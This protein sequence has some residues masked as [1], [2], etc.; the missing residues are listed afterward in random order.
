[1]ASC[2]GKGICC[3]DMLANWISLCIALCVTL[4]TRPCIIGTTLSIV[5]LHLTVHHVNS[6]H[7]NTFCSELHSSSLMGVIEFSSYN[8]LFAR[9]C[10]DHNQLKVDIGCTVTNGYAPVLA[11]FK[12]PETNLFGHSDGLGRDFSE[13]TL[14]EGSYHGQGNPRQGTEFYQAVDVCRVGRSIAEGEDSSLFLTSSTTGSVWSHSMFSLIPSWVKRTLFKRETLTNAPQHH[15]V[16]L[17]SANG[18]IFQKCATVNSQKD[19]QTAYIRLLINSTDVSSSAANMSNLILL[20]NITGLY[21][22]DVSGNSTGTTNGIQTYRKESLTAGEYFLINYI[23]SLDTKDVKNGLTFSLPALLTFHNS[24]EVTG[25]S[26]NVIMAPFTITAKESSKGNTYKINCEQ[27]MEHSQTNVTDSANEDVIMADRIIDI[28]AFEESENMLRALEDTEIT[29][30]IQTDASLE[31]CRMHIC[32]DVI[33]ILLRNMA[34]ARNLSPHEEKRLNTVLSECWSKLEKRTQEEHQRQLVALTAECNLDTRKEMDMEHRKQK[35]AN[36]EA[37]ELMKHVGEKSF[38]EYRLLLDKL[39]DLDQAKMKRL[40]LLKQEEEFAKAHRQLTVSH[41]TELHNIFFDQM[42]DSVFR[43]KIQPAVV[44]ALAEDFLKVQEEAEDLLDFM[45]ANKKYHLSGRFAFRKNLIYNIQLSDSRSRCLLNSAATQIANLINK[46]ERAK[47]M[48]ENH[49][50]LLL[51]R[52]QAEVLRVKQKLENVLKLEK[53][54]LH[55]KLTIK[56]KRQIVQKLKEQK[57][58][59]NTVQ[60]IFKTTK[61]V[62]LYLEYWKKLFCDQCQELEELFEKLDGDAIEEIKALKC[63]LTEKAIEDLR[64]IQNAVIMQ[65]MLKLN[66]PRLHLQQVVEEHKRETALLVQQLEMEE[67]DKAGDAGAALESTRRKLDDEFKLNVKEQKNLR[68]W[69]QLLFTK[70]L[71]LPLSLS[72]EDLHNIRQEFQCGFSQMD[73]TLALPKIQRRV[74]LQTYLTEWRNVELLKLDHNLAEFEKLSNS[75]MKKHPQDKNIEVLKK[76]VEDKILI[77]EAQITDDKIKQ[78]RGELLLQRVH[79][80]KNRE[81]KLGEYI[82]SLQFQWIKNKSK[83]VEIHMA[84]LHLQSLLLEGLCKSHIV[85]KSDYEQVLETRS[86]EIGEMDQNLESRKHKVANDKLSEHDTGRIASEMQL[87]SKEEEDLDMPLSATLRMVLRRRKQL[88]NLYR[89]RLFKQELENALVEDQEEKTELDIF[90]K[91][92]NQDIKLAAYLTKQTMLPEGMLHRALNLL[93]PSSSENEILPVLYAVG[94]KYSDSVTETD[95]NEDEADNRRKRK[96]QDLWT[97]IEKRLGEGLF[98]QEQEKSSFAKRKKGSI[99]KKKRLRP[100]KRVSFSHTERFSKLLAPYGHSEQIGS[101]D[102]IDLPDTREKL[103]VFR[104]PSETSISSTQHKKKR[105]FLNFK[106]SSIAHL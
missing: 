36:E 13:A 75:K 14:I 20:D 76:S 81:Y 57:K 82:A 10:K 86:H 88:T 58:E 70:I 48:D 91:F 55:Q 45:Q 21:V 93:L 25:A 44:K 79:Q 104:V 12:P 40:L 2:L 97:L 30:I 46:T 95:N 71:L 18:I 101:A 11:R 9:N 74:M 63:S 32:K 102:A 106:K 43:G 34:Y 4:L 105:N 61:E 37:E 73:I 8:S 49:T 17:S 98:N 1:M 64:Y 67:N 84:V 50:E 54:K 23:A 68:H 3:A 65:E 15:D 52:A 41:R 19:P 77:Y 39:H 33:G 31:V 7:V 6:S 35:A 27:K 24:S 99:L 66:V 60:E 89:E 47:H 38:T 100:V 22:P 90:L 51:E 62:N 16:S 85:T 29:N 83:A 59:L 26:S 80:L 103:F 94:H 72:E 56:R 78:V 53:R 42:Q 96:Y 69:E 92:Y 28:L 5:L 87:L